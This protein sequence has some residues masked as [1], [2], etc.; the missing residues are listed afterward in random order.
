MTLFSIASAYLK[1]KPSVTLLHIALLMLGMALMS[2]LLLFGHQLEQRLYRDSAGI[3]AV[4]GAKGS[5]LQLILSSIQ[6]I[7]IP[8]GNIKLADARRIQK[9]PQVKR[10]IPISLGDSYRQF[11]IVGTEP[12]YLAQFG[13]KLAE[14]E[15]WHEPLQAVIGAE[16]ARTTGLR[17][18]KEFSGSHG[19]VEGGE[20]HDAH[21]YR[22][23]GILAPT[24]GVIDRLILTSLESVWELHEEHGEHE[25]HHDAHEEHNEHDEHEEQEHHEE[26]EHHEDR[27]V[28]ALLVT[29]R[30]RAAALSFPRFVNQQTS[31]QAASPAFEMARLVNLLGV[32]SDTLLL[33]GGFL[34]AVSLVSVFIA[35]LNSIRE[36]R[37]DL[38]IFRTLGA[39]RGKLFALVLWEGMTIAL[40]GSILGLLLGHGALEAMGQLTEK[41][42]D[43]GLHGWIF[44]PQVLWLWLAVLLAAFLA[45]A[46][47]AWQ[48]GRTEIH[49][50][51]RHGG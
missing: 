6:Q 25:E 27:E 14:G 35:L 40:I 10:A 5:P 7:D 20:S 24:G 42:R 50:L 13:A 1:E 49:T 39:S 16:A 51:L 31:M 15:V 2:A 37:Y 17:I 45:C 28:T 19:L 22:V 11:R 29:Y 46:I 21:P 18:G 3:D 26:A 36:R 47:P 9:H 34:V 8:T 38:A 33:F 12:E 30:S 43:M 4:I 23:V 32:G 48:A 41:G 44:L